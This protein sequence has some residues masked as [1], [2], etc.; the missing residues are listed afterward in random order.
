MPITIAP[1][2]QKE[3]PS[4]TSEPA[5]R[6]SDK[7]RFKAG[8]PEKLGG[9]VRDGSGLNAIAGVARSILTWR[10]N[11]NQTLTAIGT[12]EKL[13]LFEQTALH[14]ITPI[15]ESQA[16]G[17]DPFSTTIS[18]TTVVVTDTAHG[19][20]QGDYVTFSGAVCT[21]LVD[22]EV[23]ANHQLTW[24]DNDSYSFEVTTAATAT[25]ANDGGASVTAD[26]ELN[27]GAV[28]QVFNYGYGA[29]AYG[30]ETYGDART[31][32]GTVTTLRY[33]SLD[34]FGE[35]LVACH[36][37]GRVYE[38]DAS[39]SNF[40]TRA[41]LISTSPTYQNT[42]LVTNPDRHLVTFAAEDTGTQDNMLVRW[43]SQETTSD[44]TP[45]AE[46]TSGSQILSG[47]SIIIAAHRSQNETLI[48]TDVGLH[49]MTFIGVPFVLS[50]NEIGTNCGAISKHC[51]INKNTVVYWMGKDDFF[52]Y[53]GTVQVI[54]CTV[55][56]HVFGNLEKSQLSKVTVG[57][58][59]QFDEVI[60]FYPSSDG[61]GEN[62]SYV[63]YN[64]EQGIWYTGMMDRTTWLDSELLETPLGINSTGTIYHH[65]Q[66]VDDDLSAMTAYIESSDF[67]IDQ[68]DK[69]M[70]ISRLIP[71]MTINAGSV[72]YIFKT[73]RYAQSTQTT[74]T[75]A[76]V[77]ATTEKVDLRIRTR[78]LAM[79][80]ES[81]ALSDSWQ[82]GTARLGVRTDGRR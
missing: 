22:A 28:S 50:F 80:V 15:R 8:Q 14:D 26:Y 57:L 58:I 46:N 34:H 33:W 16:L 68:G 78:D 37:E 12:N 41:T 20:T 60:W 76:T 73:K 35:D 43:A 75:T 27:I 42:L 23:N 1:G 69:F 49:A 52:I 45:V 77:S 10:L 18:T 59:Q 54:P 74:D 4:L 65:E 81:D 48:W 53:D 2:I 25:D 6:N 9:W 30:M 71:D 63:I 82:M 40:D 38:W 44:W 24:I 51:I 70:F 32:S 29:G 21:T 72:D 61:G 11:D 36:E 64:Y 67:D 17:N 79:R 56:R 5:W 7:I 66:G 3:T 47:G 31:I 55:H 13:Y 62:D 19:A 39:G